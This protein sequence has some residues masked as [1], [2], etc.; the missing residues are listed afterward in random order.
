VGE[1]LSRSLRGRLKVN[2]TAVKF[3]L[4]VT[5]GEWSHRTEVSFQVYTV[6]NHFPAEEDDRESTVSEFPCSSVA[7]VTRYAQNELVNRVLPNIGAPY[8]T[9]EEEQL[10]FEVAS[11]I[12]SE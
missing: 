3:Q 5:D 10:F 4:T 8:R 1:G 7:D 6:D 12:N 2:G 9:T 11:Q